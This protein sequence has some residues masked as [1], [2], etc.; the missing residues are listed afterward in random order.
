MN[1]VNKFV[2]LD[3]AVYSLD[4]IGHGKS[5]GDREF[6]QHF[7][8]FTETFSIFYDMISAWQPTIPIFIFGHSMG[9]GWSQHITYSTIKKN[10]MVP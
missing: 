5:D 1:V 9:G 7:D 8:D 2:P 10:S 6:V 4:H 3:F